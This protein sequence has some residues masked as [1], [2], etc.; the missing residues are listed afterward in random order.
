MPKKVQQ[1]SALKKQVEKTCSCRKGS[2]PTSKCA[3]WRQEVKAAQGRP[4]VPAAVT[5][6]P[7]RRTGSGKIW[8][9]CAF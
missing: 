9:L 6:R 4:L 3:Q 1:Q 5:R 2:T 7:R 8:Q